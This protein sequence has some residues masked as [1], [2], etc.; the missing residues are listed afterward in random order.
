MGLSIQSPGFC[1]SDGIP[2]PCLQGNIRISPVPELPPYAHDLVSD[3]GGDL[4]TCHIVSRSA[5][6]RTNHNVDFLRR[7]H[8][9]IILSDRNYTFFGA[10]YRPCTLDPSGFGPP[11]PVLPS[12][13]TTE[14]SAKLYSGGTSTTTLCGHPLGNI[15]E[16]H[17]PFG[18]FP[19]IRACWAQGDLG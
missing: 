9:Q 18:R 17:L 16:F 4:D 14:L 19:T 7:K 8:R 13:F 2:Q 1:L 5:V 6:F 3:P 10:Q 11:L 15:I 12:D